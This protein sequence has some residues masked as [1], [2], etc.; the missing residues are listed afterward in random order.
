MQ[1]QPIS[2]VKITLFLSTDLELIGFKTTNYLLV[3]WIKELN[4]I[5]DLKY[6]SPASPSPYS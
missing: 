3:V 6:L 5:T 1:A 4:Y 2:S